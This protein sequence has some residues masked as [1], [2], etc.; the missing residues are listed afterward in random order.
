VCG[1]PFAHTHTLY[2]E[3][4]LYAVPFYQYRSYAIVVHS[5]SNIIDNTLDPGL[6]V[7]SLMNWMLLTMSN[8]FAAYY[9]GAMGILLVY[10]V[11]DEASFNSNLCSCL[12]FMVG[13]F[14]M[15]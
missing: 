1:D 14:N 12:A 4:L 7:I 5:Y 15:F 11:T 2:L 6:I 13:S 10:D 9:R 3:K 8:S